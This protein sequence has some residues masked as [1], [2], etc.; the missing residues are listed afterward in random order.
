MPAVIYF[1]PFLQKMDGISTATELRSLLWSWQTPGFLSIN[2][3]S[4]KVRDLLPTLPGG[5]WLPLKGGA[6]DGHSCRCDSTFS[7][8]PTTGQHAPL[9]S[10][11]WGSSCRLDPAWCPSW[12]P[13]G[14]HKPFMWWGRGLGRAPAS[15]GW[16]LSACS[17]WAGLS[18]SHLRGRIVPKATAQACHF[19]GLGQSARGAA[20]PSV[21]P[22]IAKGLVKSHALLNLL[23]TL[24]TRLP[25]SRRRKRLILEL[26]RSLRGWLHFINLQSPPNSVVKGAGS[27]L[28]IFGS[29]PEQ[30]AREAYQAQVIGLD[31]NLS[32]SHH[33]FW[34]KSS[35]LNRRKA[36]LGEAQASFCTGVSQVNYHFWI[37][38]SPSWFCCSV[39]VTRWQ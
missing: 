8:F 24:S 1:P 20:S 37:L 18:R 23:M 2:F 35:P 17:G 30:L 13:W 3:V 10:Q 15:G 29:V 4:P 34:I 16:W 27:E 21:C 26:R 7:P 5:T 28:T 33:P 38:C 25:F 19:K 32:P 9:H 36:A 6:C 39:G 14:H 11:G 12:G 22:L 31:L